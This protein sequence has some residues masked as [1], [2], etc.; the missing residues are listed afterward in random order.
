MSE[1]SFEK[2]NKFSDL[3]D[4]MLP[5]MRHLVENAMPTWEQLEVD[6]EVYDIEIVYDVLLRLQSE[7]EADKEYY[8]EETM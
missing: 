7:L 3:L 4:Q 5:L 8:N 2:V 1:L 6:H